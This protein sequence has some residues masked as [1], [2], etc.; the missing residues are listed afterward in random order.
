MCLGT[1][2]LVT[3]MEPDRCVRVRAGDRDI[4]ASLLAVT[5]TVGPGDWVLV[6]SGLVLS[7]LTEQEARDALELR[8]PTTEGIT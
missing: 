7:R 2:G 4:T 8:D 3:A 6:H 5:D 1:V